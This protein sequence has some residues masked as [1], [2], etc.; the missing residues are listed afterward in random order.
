MA[1]YHKGEKLWQLREFVTCK[2]W[3]VQIVLKLSFEFV[4]DRIGT[5]TGIKTIT[6]VDTNSKVA[7]IVPKEFGDTI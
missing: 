7:M 1:Q 6:I 2:M 5:T 4:V 3:V